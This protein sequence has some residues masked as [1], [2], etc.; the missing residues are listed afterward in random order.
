LEKVVD[1]FENIKKNMDKKL[2]DCEKAF[3][4]EKEAK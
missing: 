4:I 2:K 1:D 3:M